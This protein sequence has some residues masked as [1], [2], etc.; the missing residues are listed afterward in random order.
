MGA[1]I[2]AEQ[3]RED[4]TVSKFNHTDF[5]QPSIIARIHGEHDGPVTIVGCHLDSVNIDNPLNGTSP[6][7]DDDGSGV[8]NLLEALRVL[9]AAD[10]KPATP[11]EFHW[12]AAE[13]AGLRGSA[14]IATYYKVKEVEVKGMMQL[15]MTG[16]F[17]P[18]SER[19]IALVPDFVDE[20]LNN[21]VKS[22]VSEYNSVPWA[23]EEPVSPY[24]K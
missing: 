4:I 11:V 22:L 17:K 6:G 18:G 7:A 1:Q 24:L 20:G 2:V 14:Q 13:E 23:D 19:V 21:F 16:Y 5:P 12:Y 8:V 15:D 3:D 10:F 9:L